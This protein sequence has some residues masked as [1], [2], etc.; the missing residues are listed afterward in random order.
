MD[1][2]EQIQKTRRRMEEAGEKQERRLEQRQ[3][4]ALERAG[5]IPFTK[6]RGMNR[7]RLVEESMGV[8]PGSLLKDDPVYSPDQRRFDYVYGKDIVAGA[9]NEPDG[10]TVTLGRTEFFLD[11]EGLNAL[12]RQIGNV[13]WKKDL[14][15]HRKYPVTV[16]GMDTWLTV[17][18]VC[19]LMWDIGR[20][21][22]PKDQDAV[23]FAEAP[24]DTI[25]EDG[26][27]R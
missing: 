26:I 13:D 2:L 20:L 14:P 18:D 22:R 12:I 1:A 10:Y 5:R 7:H 11:E 3:E 16:G 25:G 19:R 21:E 15:G 9:R 23:R 17:R 8:T 24:E 6:N 27:S 4:R